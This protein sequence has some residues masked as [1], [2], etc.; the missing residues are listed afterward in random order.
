MDSRVIHV[1]DAPGYASSRT[2]SLSELLINTV[3][4]SLAGY[5]T[6]KVSDLLQRIELTNKV[7]ENTTSLKRRSTATIP[8]CNGQL[9]V[10]YEFSRMHQRNENSVARELVG[11]VFLQ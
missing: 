7:C 6:E 2:N 10:I 11:V 5:S 4:D 1:V 8:H 3:N 9:E